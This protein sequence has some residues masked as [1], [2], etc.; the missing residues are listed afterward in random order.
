[1]KIE[2]LIAL[3]KVAPATRNISS[4][5]LKHSIREL[6]DQSL[7]ILIENIKYFHKYTNVVIYSEYVNRFKQYS[8]EEQVSII[9][10]VLESLKEE[11]IYLH[12]IRIASF[13]NEL[14]LNKMTIPT[15]VVL[16]LLDSQ[17][18]SIRKIGYYCMISQR[19]NSLI[20]K[21]IENHSQYNDDILDILMNYDITTETKILL[22]NYLDEYYV[23]DDYLEFFE[24]VVRNRLLAKLE[25]Y[26]KQRINE[27]REKDPL[28]YVFVMKSIKEQI[29]TDY[30]IKTFYS[31]D[32]IKLYLISWY[33]E[34]GNIQAVDLILENEYKTIFMKADA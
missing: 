9:K 19:Y 31:F 4:E 10:R 18:Y 1:M 8:K 12:K 34:L 13:I 6:D 33:I 3:L 22:K 30:L 17:Y 26:E 28:S 25:K 32:P 20:C 29:D 5:I 7:N 11:S 14:V 21:V 27:L 16:F 23:D 24:R 15:D 2:K